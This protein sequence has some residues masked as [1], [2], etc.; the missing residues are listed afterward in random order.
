MDLIDNPD[1]PLSLCAVTT[2]WVRW[3]DDLRPEDAV[4]GWD[5]FNWRCL[6]LRNYH[7]DPQFFCTERC[8]YRL[9]TSVIE[10]I[11]AARV[12]TRR[13][14]PQMRMDLERGLL[15]A[16]IERVRE[17]PEIVDALRVVYAE[18][19]WNTMVLTACSYTGV[20][21][22]RDFNQEELP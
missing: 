22:I 7:R 18:A 1:E 12:V 2:A 8:V 9:L 20:T 15:P 19:G 13:T 5:A 21:P 3:I 10:W 14:K 4:A 16:L 11:D 6:I 17:Q